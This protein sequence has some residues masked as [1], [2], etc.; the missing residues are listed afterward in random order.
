MRKV[1]LITGSVYHVFN[2][3]IAKYIIFNNDAE[4]LRFFNVICYYQREKPKV[5]F[6]RFMRDS[7][8]KN[9]FNG[10]HNQL[11]DKKKI[12]EI[13]AYCLMPTH[14]HLVLTQL[15]DG[16]ISKFLNN[17]QN[18]Y[19]R[20]FNLK[21]KRRGPLWESRFKNVLVDSD[22]QLLHLTRYVHL[23]PVKANII[24]RT[25]DWPMSSYKEYISESKLGNA[26]CDFDKILEIEP[27]TY[28]DFIE[29]EDSY[30]QDLKN[31]RD[32]FLDVDMN[33]SVTAGV[34][35]G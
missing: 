34:N 31:M 9:E 16:G 3:S 6:S 25:Q 26:I 30:Q 33:L 10:M 28:K 8:S 4:F 22:E 1:P 20:Y 35:S 11:N 17:I 14:F 23:N 15:V 2:R 5:E 21:H 29:D 19:S 12:V 18:S 24:K 32:I 27:D 13:I 7:E